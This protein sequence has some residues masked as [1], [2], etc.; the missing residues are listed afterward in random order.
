MFDFTSANVG[1]LMSVVYIERIPTVSMVDG[2]EVR[3]VRVK[4]EAL[5]PTRIAGV[6]GKNFR[7]TGLEKTEAEN[8][9]KLLRAEFAGRA[10]GFRRRT[11][12]RPEP[13]RGKRRARHYRGALAPSSSPLA[14]FTVYYRMFG[15]ITSVALLM[16]LLIV[17]AVMSMFGATDDAARLRRPGAVGRSA[18]A[19]R[20]RADQ[21][22]Y[23]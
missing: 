10:D 11:H 19:R 6:F 4:E 17:V 18:P 3:S 15:V 21:R 16:N 1:K 14:F 23:P 22:A 13:G 2:Q 12:H 8:L 9:A 7:T 5:A 20:Q